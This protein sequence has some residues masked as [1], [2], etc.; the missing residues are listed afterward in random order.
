M[1][2]RNYLALRDTLR[3]EP[4][5]RDEYGAVKLEASKSEYDNVMQYAAKK[6]DVVRKIL[7]KAGWSE[8]EIDDKES[9]AVKDWPSR[10]VVI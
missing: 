7:R 2:H 10:P 6:N 1:P 4:A 5:L 9:Q 8:E 3:R